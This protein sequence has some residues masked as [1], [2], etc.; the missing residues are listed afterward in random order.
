MKK[1]LSILMTIAILFTLVPTQTAKAAVKISK[2]KATMEVDSTLTLKISGTN[3][4]VSWS[5]DKKSVATV[6]NKGTVTAIKSGSATIT[7]SVEGNKYSCDVNVVDSNKK[8]IEFELTAGEYIV[9][10]DIPTGKYNLKGKDG[11]GF[12]FVY[13]NE[14]DYENDKLYNKSINMCGG[15]YVKSLSG[16]Y[17]ETYS[18]LNLKSK[19]YLVVEGTIN[20]QFKSK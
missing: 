9:G 10:D 11:W 20:V 16:M 15:E 19:Q 8:V 14:K 7:A 6:N 12:V 5:T 13:K 17:S 18:K 4:K 1:L 2:S 3:S